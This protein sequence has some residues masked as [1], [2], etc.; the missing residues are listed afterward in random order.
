MSPLSKVNFT[1][2]QTTIFIT[3]PGLSAPTCT[4]GTAGLQALISVNPTSLDFGQQAVNTTS[5]SKTLSVQNTGS[6]PTE[7]T[8]YLIKGDFDQTNDCGVLSAGG[9]CRSSW[10]SLQKR[11]GAQ[12]GDIQVLTPQDKVQVSL[13]GTGK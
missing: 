12:S 10:L 9:T 11:K 5:P 2:S 7:V 1:V 4:P 13:K 8:G 3:A 6:A